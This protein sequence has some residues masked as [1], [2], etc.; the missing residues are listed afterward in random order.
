MRDFKCKRER[1]DERKSER[2]YAH[3]F[4]DNHSG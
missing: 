4:A 1:N 3:L 2:T